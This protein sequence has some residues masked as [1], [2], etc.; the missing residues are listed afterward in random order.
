MED[1]FK[2]YVE[3]LRGGH[4]EKIDENVNSSFL[5][6]KEDDLRF[7]DIT[8]IKG[9]AYLAEN[10]LVIHLDV[11]V[12]AYMPCAICNKAVKTPLDLKNLYLTA[13][14][15]EYK[16]G[17]YNFS[18]SLRES[19]LLELPH[20]V[21]CDGECPQRKEISD[22]LKDPENSNDQDGGFHPFADLD[23]DEKDK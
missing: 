3:Q 12:I 1:A 21:E 23:F 10:E 5:D 16:S 17:I 22:Y 11:H 15:E 18:E 6:I 14:P 20:F 9:E 2:I 19:I 13:E 7:D 8:H 4:V